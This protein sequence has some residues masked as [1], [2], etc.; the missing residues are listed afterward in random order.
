MNF[1]QRTLLI[2]FGVLAFS[3]AQAQELQLPVVEDLK[4]RGYFSLSADA[5]IGYYPEYDFK[6]ER[7]VLQFFGVYKLSDKSPLATSMRFAFAR[8]SK[9]GKFVWGASYQRASSSLRIDT[10]YTVLNRPDLPLVT[11]DGWEQSDVHNYYH[12]FFE[13]RL[14]T[15]DRFSLHGHLSLGL[16]WLELEFIDIPASGIIQAETP[17]GGA[18]RTVIATRR[19]DNFGFL[20]AGN[21][22]GLTGRYR[23]NPYYSLFSSLRLNWII[24][25]Y[26]IEQVEFA[27]GVELNLRKGGVPTNSYPGK[28]KRNKN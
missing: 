12:F 26:T 7:E 19:Y 22:L 28:R 3:R 13:P 27:V 1:F 20:E 24:S 2:V 5:A 10:T 14:M 23:L 17:F 11:F 15:R 21:S 9:T 18:G 25:T 8:H 4:P 16:V 6:Q